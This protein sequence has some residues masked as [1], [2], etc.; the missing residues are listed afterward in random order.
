MSKQCCLTCK[1]SWFIG[2]SSKLKTARCAN[3]DSRKFRMCLEVTATC[4]WWEG[5]DKPVHAYGEASRE[6]PVTYGRCTCGGIVIDRG[7]GKTPSMCDECRRD[8]RRERA[9]KYRRA[10]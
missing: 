4:G 2:E 3:P 9:R 6:R 7:Y 10:G 8:V 1:H 5:S